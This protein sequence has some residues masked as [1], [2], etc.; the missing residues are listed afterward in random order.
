MRTTSACWSIPIPRSIR[1]K[2]SDWKRLIHL[3]KLINYAF[4][5]FTTH[6]C[7]GIYFLSDVLATNFD[8]KRS[9]QYTILALA[10]SSLKLSRHFHFLFIVTDLS[11]Q[12]QNFQTS[13]SHP[14]ND[15]R[16]LLMPPKSRPSNIYFIRLSVLT[17]S[18]E[19][20]S[21][22]RIAVS[23]EAT[24]LAHSTVSHLFQTIV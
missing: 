6:G 16:T 19:F 2:H 17:F 23:L 11:K 7:N 1:V 14:Q 5:Y 21:Y 13:C 15:K 22:S 24:I 3:L 10:K 4:W 20:T 18:L 9:P 12:K 8:F